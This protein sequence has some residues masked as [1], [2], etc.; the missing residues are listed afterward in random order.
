MYCP[1]VIMNT[2]YALTLGFALILLLALTVYLFFPGIMV[3][4]AFKLA[5]L[6]A[7]L[8]LKRVKAGRYHWAYLD[9]GSGEPIIFIHGFGGSKDTWGRMP[10]Y[11]T[12][13]YR[14]IIPDLAGT[15]DSQIIKDE[16]VTITSAAE[17]LENFV[18]ALGLTSFH[19]VGISSGGSIAAYYASRYPARV[20]SASLIGPFGIQT[21]IVT[22]FRQA[23]E[24]GFNHIV[25]RTPEGFDHWMSY[26][27]HR[28]MNIPWRIKSSLA[29]KHSRL[30]DYNIRTFDNVI[31][32]EGW[33]M[34]RGHLKKITCPVFI[35]FGNRDRITDVK[36]LEVFSTEISNLKTFIMDDAGHITYL[37]KPVETTNLLKDFIRSCSTV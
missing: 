4:V 36:C 2:L 30:Y 17:E 22:E 28:P 31:N 8:K 35:I 25:C 16:L 27:A 19:L 26:I 3:S 32:T 10:G 6:H 23:Y 29:K 21:D 11:F 24:K 34:L 18:C 7:G 20:K 37:D 5:R 13:T 12:G 15:N 14:V 1:D 9:G 33:D